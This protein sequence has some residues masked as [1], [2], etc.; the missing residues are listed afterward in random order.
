MCGDGGDVPKSHGCFR[1]L[2]KH[3]ERSSSL[4]CLQAWE[5]RH[6]SLDGDHDETIVDWRLL[7]GRAVF[8]FIFPVPGIWASLVAQTVKNL[9]AMQEVWVWPRGRGDPRRRARQ[10]TPVNLPGEWR[11]SLVGCSPWRGKEL[12]MT[13]RLTLS[14]F[15]FQ[16]V[17]GVWLFGIHLLSSWWWVTP[18]SEVPS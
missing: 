8:G 7:A 2:T 15:S 11:N 4:E 1:N 6:S 16:C 18:S 12:D 14:S 13:E 9:P 10:P 5:T 17:K 3:G